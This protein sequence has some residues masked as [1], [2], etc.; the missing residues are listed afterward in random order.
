VSEGGLLGERERM[1]GSR[2]KMGGRV[3]WCGLWY[4]GSFV[5]R[6]SLDGPKLEVLH[7][8]RDKPASAY[9]VMKSVRERYRENFETAHEEMGIDS[10][11]RRT[12]ERHVSCLPSS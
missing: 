4:L 6:R 10:N 8:E 12:N 2:W 7:P 3:A 11:N 5:F 1:G 9:G